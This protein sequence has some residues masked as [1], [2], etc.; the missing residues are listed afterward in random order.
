MSVLVLN[1]GGISGGLTGIIL[2]NG[3]SETDV[4]AA[5][6]DGK[7]INGKWVQKL[8]PDWRGLPDGFIQLSHIEAT[9]TQHIDTNY[10][11]NTNTKI[12]ICASTTDTANDKPLFG[13]RAS[14][15]AG[16]F[17]CWFNLQNAT[18]P[19]VAF[20]NTGNVSSNFGILSGVKHVLTLKNGEFSMDGKTV[21]LTS[22][23]FASSYN[24]LL[25]G[26]ST[27]GTV[28]SRKFYGNIYSA[29]LHESNVLVRDYVPAKRNSDGAIGLYDIANGVFY[30]NAGSGVFNAGAEVPRYVYCHEISG[31]RETGVWTVTATDGAKTKTQDVLLEVI[32]LYEIEMFIPIEVVTNFAVKESNWT[33]HGGTVRFGNG[34]YVNEND[35]K[36]T[37][38]NSDG[39]LSKYLDIPCLVDTFDFSFVGNLYSDNNIRVYGYYVR[40]L[41]EDGNVLC[42]ASQSDWWGANKNQV[43]RMS[44]YGS[45]GS[46]SGFYDSSSYNGVDVTWRAVYDGMTMS[47]Y[48]NGTLLK[49]F[50]CDMPYV[51]TTVRIEFEAGSKSSD[52][53]PQCRIKNLKLLAL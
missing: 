43:G 2:V 4:V 32:G 1:R 40:L 23:S 39:Q 33:E 20:G 24:L 45:G 52:T 7:T 18:N 19:L 49:E 12:E 17:L 22:N 34:V 41:D 29:K 42:Q 31:I 37:I 44:G 38:V 30:A 53:N 3:L 47:Y 50:D 6:K 46:V 28:D 10:K 9:G 36:G 16:G 48:M 5:T 13:V 35:T 8:N 26:L 25:L 14:T 21:S 11:P 15:S 51:G 27:A